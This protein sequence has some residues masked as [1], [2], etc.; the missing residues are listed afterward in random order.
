MRLFFM[1]LLFLLLS[2]YAE[3]FVFTSLSRYDSTDFEKYWL[4]EHLGEQLGKAK[5]HFLEQ[6]AIS[7]LLNRTL[8]LPNVGNSEIGLRLRMPFSYYYQTDDLTNI[9]RTLSTADF[10]NRMMNIKIKRK[11]RACLVF[12]GEHTCPV[13]KLSWDSVQNTIFKDLSKIFSIKKLTPICLLT[14]YGWKPPTLPDAIIQKLSSL[15]HYVDIVVTVKES[16]LFL[17]DPRTL[18]VHIL[19]HN[20]TLIEI[21]KTFAKAISP[22]LAIH[23]RMEGGY[24]DGRLCARRLLETVANVS[25]LH[26]F[27]NIYFATDHPSPSERLISNSFSQS[28]TDQTLGYCEIM[29]KLK[30]VT[31]R[32]LSYHSSIADSGTLS[33][34]EKLICQ[35][36]DFF[37]SGYVPCDRNGAYGREMVKYRKFI[38]K[39]PW[40]YWN[41]PLQ[42]YEPEKFY[43]P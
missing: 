43:P 26:F 39:K 13:E 24:E 5:F 8:V 32:N 14:S 42:P 25:N 38:S 1:L 23:W 17:M 16:S 12:I 29:N 37:L 9:V 20:R 31:F 28:R 4:I 30:P 35:E 41:D 33:I 11:L 40:L 15:N 22:F 3:R 27:K 36:S 2:L 19:K 21:A 18:P 34:L 7:N 6:M 10:I